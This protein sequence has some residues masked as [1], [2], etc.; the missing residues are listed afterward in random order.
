[1]LV[2]MQGKRRNVRQWLV[3]KYLLN[4][5]WVKWEILACRHKI[6]IQILTRPKQEQ[7]R[8]A[9][10]HIIRQF[11]DLKQVSGDISVKLEAAFQ[12]RDVQRARSWLGEELNDKTSH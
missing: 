5:C 6:Y 4:V 12:Y 10:V 11:L 8:L 3:S 9:L 7:A 2:F 1:M